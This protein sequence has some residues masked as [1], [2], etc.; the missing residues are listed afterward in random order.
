MRIAISGSTGLVGTQLTRHFRDDGH[1]VTRIV[2]SFS[3]LPQGERAVVWD[4]ARGNIEQHGLEGHDIVIHLAGESLA[5]VWT[6]AKKRRILD[7]RVQ[8]TTLLSRTIA[9]LDHKPR[10]LVT[11]SG[12]NVYGDRG[13]TPV[14]EET[15]PGSGFLVDVV[16]AWESSADPARQAGIRVVHMRLGNVLSPNGGLLGMLLPLFKLGLGTTLGGGGQY[17]PWIA[18]EEIAPALEHVIERPELNGPVNFVAPQQVTNAELTDAIARAV[19]R[20]SILR[21]PGFAAR[22]APGD[23]ADELLLGSIRVV[24]RKL[25]DSGYEFRHPELKPALRA[26]LARS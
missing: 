4:P 26:M 13:N 1:H 11:A 2:R 3:G 9:A 22:L 25:L 21:L 20:P 17:W 12:I 8:G 15:P 6:D 23:M 16:R 18:L 14:D 10:V 24:P 5:G 7:S 19:H